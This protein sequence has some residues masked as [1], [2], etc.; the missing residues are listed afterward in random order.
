[1]GL[2]VGIVGAPGAGQTALFNALTKAGVAAHDLKEHV[3]MAPIADERL[4]QLAAVEKAR[5]VTPAA[6]R[7]VDVPGTGPQLLGNLRQVDALLRWCDRRRGRGAPARAARRRPRPRRAA[8]RARA[9]AGEVGRPE[10]PQGGRRPGAAAR[11]RRGGRHGRGL[12]RGASA[13]ARPA[14]DEAGRLV[15]NGPGG[16]DLEL[17]EEL[18]ELAEEEAAEFRDGGRSALDEIAAS[19]RTRST[20][21]RSSPPA[22][23]RRARGRSATARPRSTPPRR[24][25]PTSPAASSAAR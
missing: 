25:T 16:I 8:A 15:V 4:A 9:P 6:I 5:K 11:P 20:S 21:S 10:A 7:V 12:R 17:E 18:A 19:S 3:G 2:E 23:R 1:M 22:T 13:R 24:S 14:D